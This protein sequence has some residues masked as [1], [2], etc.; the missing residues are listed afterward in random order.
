M[1]VKKLDFK[2]S[3]GKK[4]AVNCR[5]LDEL[6]DF[7][8]ALKEELGDEIKNIVT[9]AL[10]S[11][12]EEATYCFDI[13]DWRCIDSEKTKDYTFIEWSEYMK[14]DKKI[15]LAESRMEG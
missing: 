12:L 5:N 13:N 9:L 10:I 2:A 15:E 11:F 7:M 6:R 8:G 1:N 4:I 3:N 14:K